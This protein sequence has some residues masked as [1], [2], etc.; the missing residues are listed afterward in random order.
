VVKLAGFAQDALHG[1]G[2]VIVTW[3]TSLREATLGLEK[4]AFTG[5]KYSLIAVAAACLA[6]LLFGVGPWVGMFLASGPTR[7]LFLACVVTSVALYVD[8]TR[9]SGA[10]PR[11]APAFPIAL[12]LFCYV[13]ARAAL[14]AVARGEVR[15]R[16]R[17][18]PLEQLRRNRI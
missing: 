3:Y 11:F 1:T 5:L 12:V 7:L 2:A 15:W 9:S 13:L 16:G 4:N 18:Y 10:D 17:G 14:L 8:S 6:I